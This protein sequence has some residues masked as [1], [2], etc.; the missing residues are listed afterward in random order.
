MENVIACRPCRP[1]WSSSH[2]LRKDVVARPHK[3][4]D[5]LFRFVGLRVTPSPPPPAAA[6]GGALDGDADADADSDADVDAD[7]AG[8]GGGASASVAAAV[9][10]F[11]AHL[12]VTVQ[13]LRDQIL[14][15]H[16]IPTTGR[17][18]PRADAAPRRRR[19]E[20]ER[21]PGVASHYTPLHH[22][23]ACRS[24]DIT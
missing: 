4:V 24:H 20:H 8:G 22:S 14:M 12:A 11:H 9:G 15:R 16:V 19:L 2:G 18:V 7:A 6:A 1:S 5:A 13:W 17:A 23:T 21:A 3:A 10:R